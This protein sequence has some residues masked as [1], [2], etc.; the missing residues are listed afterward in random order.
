[1]TPPSTQ[2]LFDT[3]EATWPPAARHTKGVWT[4]RDGAGGGKRVSA[5][6]A[7]GPITQADIAELETEMPTPL[8]MV[9]EG[10]DALDALL[11][12]AGYEIVDPTCLYAAPINTMACPLPEL[13]AIPHWPWLA[14]TSEI[15]AA[16]GIGKSRLMVM[17]RAS[18]PKTAFLARADDTPAG[19]AFVSMHNDIAMIHA[20]EVLETMRR[21]G[22]ARNMMI[23]A[24]NWAQNIGASWFSLAVTK[25]NSAA[26]ALYTSL[27]LQLVGHYHY[28]IKSL[29][30]A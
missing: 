12:S 3:L 22:A 19:A 7:N 17:E 2:I 23:A 24:A 20:I 6:T 28:R 14:V 16:G 30:K 25:Q 9:R 13:S 18:G 15:W 10:E 29:R 8:V 26:R 11:E 21:K 5:A 4:F 1:M 27:G